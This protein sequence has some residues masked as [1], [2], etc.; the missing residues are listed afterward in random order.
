MWGPGL[1]ELVKLPRLER[2]CFWGARGGGT[3]T[4]R[5]IKYIEGLTQLKGL[6]LQGV[7]ALTDASL[8]SIG[9]LRNLEELY[10]T[11]CSPRFTPAGAAHLKELKNLKKISFAQIMWSGHGSENNSDEV[12][13]HLSA[14]PNLEFIQGIGYLTAEGMKTLA[15]FRNLKYLQVGLKNHIMGYDGPTG[16]SHLAG[17]ASLEDLH[18]YNHDSLSEADIACLE[19]LGRLKKLNVGSRHLTDR[20]MVSFG[21]LK[22]LESLSISGIPGASKINKSGLNQLNGLTNLRYLKVGLWGNSA[23][24]NPADELMLDLSGLKKMK[25]MNLALSLQDSDLVFLEHL[26]QLEKLM[27]QPEPDS[28]LNGAFMRHLSELPELNRLYVTELSGCTG[29][30]L[31][32]LNGLPK[33]R[34]LTLSGQITDTSLASLTGPLSLE[35]IRI[36]TDEPISKQTV[37]DLKNSHPVIEFIHINELY[38]AQTR[39]V[40]TPKRTRVNQPRTNRRTP[41]NRRRE[42]R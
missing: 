21:K 35:S 7:D 37:T 40:S 23:K 24:A 38:K 4:D 28:P 20:N 25:D 36:E 34:D 30:D 31:A 32:H 12:V 3:L 22:Q 26:P 27:I 5:H 42:R 15:S 33:L 29:E 10:F 17:L 18:I 6:T 11:R 39:P 19:T 41:A 2:L 14:L 13:R 1:G 9:K 8:A 16:V